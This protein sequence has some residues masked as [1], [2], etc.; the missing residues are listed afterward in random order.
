MAEGRKQTAPFILEQAPQAEKERETKWTAP[1]TRE[2]PPR[3]RDQPAGIEASK[4]MRKA[5]IC[6]SPGNLLDATFPE[7]HRQI[8][9]GVSNRPP[10]EVRPLSTRCHTLPLPHAVFHFGSSPRC[11]RGGPWQP[12]PGARH[13][14][15]S[16]DR[17]HRLLVRL[18][19]AP[20]RVGE[21]ELGAN[22]RFICRLIAFQ[23]RSRVALEQL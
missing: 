18:Q 21:L 2:C 17:H 11:R 6:N 22:H 23:P 16:L 1:S 12:T 14:P 13:D 5:R 10:H 15:S 20:N 19:S 3:Q 8:P 4:G 9:P 7:F